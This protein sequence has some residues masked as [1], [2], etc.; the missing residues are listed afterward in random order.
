MLSF[1]FAVRYGRGGKKVSEA[2][3]LQRCTAR[4]G[5]FPPWIASRRDQLWPARQ[6]L[7]QNKVQNSTVGV[8]LRF[9][10]RVD[11]HQRLELF[12]LVLGRGAHR[13]VLSRRKM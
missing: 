9:L 1:A 8:I 3:I 2:T 10:R 5:E 6:Q 7:P 13:Q 11:A 4:R 12:L